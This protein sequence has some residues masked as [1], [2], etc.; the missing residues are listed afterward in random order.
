[1]DFQEIPIGFAVALAQ[2]SAAM[3]AYAAL[4]REAQSDILTRERSDRA[5]SEM[6]RLV[7][8]SAKRQRAGKSPPSVCKRPVPR[9]T[10]TY[11]CYHKR[12]EMS[13]F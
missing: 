13:T 5:E 7:S 10:P 1:M 6:H 3:E 11:L 4:P 2:S 12:A 8:G 9:L